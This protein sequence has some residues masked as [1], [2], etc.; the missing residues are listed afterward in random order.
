MNEEH[1]QEHAL[2]TADQKQPWFK[3]F[4]LKVGIFLIII[5]S[6]L[7]VFISFWLYTSSDRYKYDIA[8]PDVKREV[9]V[10]VDESTLDTQSAVD[11]K[12][13][14]ALQKLL[15]KQ[16]ED[17]TGINDFNA[18]ALSNETLQLNVE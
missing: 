9:T 11:A 14:E 16:E 10:D 2:T 18:R 13:V 12:G 15:E 17:L 4:N 1:K 5:V 8:R 6:L 3:S 7:L